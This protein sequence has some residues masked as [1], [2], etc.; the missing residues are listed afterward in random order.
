MTK[1]ERLKAYYRAPKSDETLVIQRLVNS[2]NHH[3][4]EYSAQEHTAVVYQVRPFRLEHPHSAIYK[5]P[6]EIG[7]GSA[8]RETLYT[9]DGR[10]YCDY[11]LEDGRKGQVVKRYVKKQEALKTLLFYLKDIKVYWDQFAY[12]R[13][14]ELVGDEG[15]VEVALSRSPYENLAQYMEASL[16]KSLFKAEDKLLMKCLKEL[17]RIMKEEIACLAKASIYGDIHLAYVDDAIGSGMDEALYATYY[18]KTYDMILKACPDIR[19]IV[20]AKDS[21]PEDMTKGI[22]WDSEAEDAEAIEPSA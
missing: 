9:P 19:L 1:K 3:I 6:V 5:K 2:E 12:D 15:L 10:L 20:S 7:K 21:L 17:T 16:L 11:L 13:A 8:E 14:V 4:K 18:R 22:L